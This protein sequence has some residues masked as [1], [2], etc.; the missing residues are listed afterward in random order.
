M[1]AAGAGREGGA[2]ARV[3]PANTSM[4]DRIDK[5]VV[6]GSLVVKPTPMWFFGNRKAERVAPRVAD[7]E[8]APS[9]LKVPGLLLRVLF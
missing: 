6:R 1:R 2:A 8:A 3:R 5:A 9:W 7:L 4:L